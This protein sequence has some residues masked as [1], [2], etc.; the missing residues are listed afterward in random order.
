MST[1]DRVMRA[2]E[3]RYGIDPG[4]AAFVRAELSKFID[5]LLTF[6]GRTPTM[7]PDVAVRSDPR[8]IPPEVPAFAWR[9]GQRSFKIYVDGRTDGPER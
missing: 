8:G 2:Y 3:S 5:E 6:P 4:R 7:F 9:P 1:I